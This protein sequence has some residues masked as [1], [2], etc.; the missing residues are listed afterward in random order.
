MK[1]IAVVIPVFNEGHTIK[2]LYRRLDEALRPVAYE[3]SLI[4]V[5]D[6]SRDAT[7]GTLADIQHSDRRV[8][9]IEL[10]RNWGQQCAYNAG[11]DYADADAVILMD[12]DLEDP[13]EVIPQLIAEWEKGHDIVYAVKTYRETRFI[14]KQLIKLFYKGMEW[15]SLVKVDHQ[16]GMFSLLDR[17]AITMIKKCTERH[18]YYVGLRSYVGFRQKSITYARQKRFA[19]Q[20]R[21]TFR[22]LINYAL[23]A[24]FA[25]SFFPIRLLTYFGIAIIAIISCLCVALTVHRF[26]FYEMF[27]FSPLPGYISLVMLI[28]FILGVQIIFM[29]ILG[30]YIVRIFDEVRNRPYYI[31]SQITDHRKK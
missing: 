26:F 12:G 2:E 23:D 5:D 4:F 29:G 11:I 7:V 18:K 30:E 19:G 22:K 9:I 1:S 16:S 15:F 20:S 14:K 6:G 13:P 21:Q 10:S 25:F 28:C 3:I 31:V 17:A 27:P 24:F 8:V